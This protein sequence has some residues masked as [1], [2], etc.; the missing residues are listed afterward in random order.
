MSDNTINKSDIEEKLRE[1]LGLTKQQANEVTRVIHSEIAK[2]LMNGKIFN[3]SRLLKLEPVYKKARPGRN[4]KTGDEVQIPARWEV[5]AS[6]A[7][8]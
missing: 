4:P 6:L 1:E 7:L 3:W 8:S 5:K 2:A